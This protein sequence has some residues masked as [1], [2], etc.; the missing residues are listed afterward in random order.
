M[1]LHGA[2][3]A[4][5]NVIESYAYRTYARGLHVSHIKEIR[6]TSFGANDDP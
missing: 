6:K 4:F 3:D 5:E 2:C 1:G